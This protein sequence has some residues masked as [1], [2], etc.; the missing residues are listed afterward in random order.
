MIKDVSETIENEAK[1][2][3]GG[4]LSTLLRTLAA[5]II[6]NMLAG[7]LKYQDKEQI[8]KQ[9]RQVII[10]DAASSFNNFQNTKI[11]IKMN[12]NLMVFVLQI[13]YLKPRMRYM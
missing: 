5:R 8:K 11:F 3:N 10:F 1:E 6:G 4:F 7:K 2:Q 13:I 9:L 12:L